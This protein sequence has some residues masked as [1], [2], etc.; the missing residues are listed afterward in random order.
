MNEMSLTGPCA[1][2]EHDLV[3][4]VEGSLGPE[5]ARVIRLHVESCARCRAWQAEFA[6]F[7]A[8]LAAALPSP[9]LSADFE[10]RLQ[11][12]AFG[13]V[14]SAAREH[15]GAV[16]RSETMMRAAVSSGRSSLAISAPSWR[17]LPTSATAGTTC[18]GAAGAG[19]RRDS[20]K[21]RVES[22]ASRVVSHSP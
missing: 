8:G 22:A 13:E 4:L 15:G 6:A 18:T 16:Q 3:E 10:R 1:D 12:R 5:R 7:D 9:A 19:K 14:A 20:P 17:L 2:Y 21:A 11:A